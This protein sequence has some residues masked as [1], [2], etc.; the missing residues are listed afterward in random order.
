EHWTLALQ[1]EAK[2]CKGAIVKDSTTPSNIYATQCK[3]DNLHYMLKL[4]E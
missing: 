4:I 3:Q 2:H 1:V